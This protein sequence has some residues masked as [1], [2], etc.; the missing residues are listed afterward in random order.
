MLGVMTVAAARAC[1]GV[2]THGRRHIRV[3]V[4]SGGRYRNAVTAIDSSRRF[5]PSNAE[6]RVFLDGWLDYYRATILCTS[7]RTRPRTSNPYPD[8]T[9]SER[10]VISRPAAWS[11]AIRRAKSDRAG[12]I[13]RTRRR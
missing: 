2:R 1:V 9:T 5:P 10:E 8:D 6:E 11:T 12:V 4:R 3:N 7:N 13:V